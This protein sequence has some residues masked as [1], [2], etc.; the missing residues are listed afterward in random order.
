VIGRVLDIV[1]GL[2]GP[3]LYLVTAG[4]AFAET[5]VGLDLLVPG[6]AGMVIAGAAGHRGGSPLPLLVGAAALGATVGDSVSYAIGRRFGIHLLERWDL[7]RRRVL[8][9]VQRAEGYFARHGG[10]AVFA[11]RWV[12]ALRAMVPVVAGTARMPFPRFLVWNVAASLTWAGTVVTLGYY[13]GGR[14]ADAVDRV[15]G[16]VSVTVIALLV[17]F[18]V[19]GHRR[20]RRDR[21]PS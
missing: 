6:E 21:L 11:G 17:A 1:A 4:L 5:A 14:V 15:G 12:G 16:W 20:R 18:W 10:R 9:A 19:I 3:A 2:A 13:A 7:T 8:P